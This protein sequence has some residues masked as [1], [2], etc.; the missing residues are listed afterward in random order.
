MEVWMKRGLKGLEVCDEAGAETLRRIKQQDV[1]KVAITKPRNVRFHRKFFALLNLVWSASGEW[2]SIE[3]LLVELKVRLG[4]VKEVVIRGTGE[5][6]KVPGSIA[7]ASMD[8][9][10][11]AVFFEQSMRELCEMAGGI[12]Y[13]A[14]R[15]E[16]LAQV[17][18]A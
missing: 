15:N 12:Q 4:L 14:L 3:D 13:E 17:S 8:D 9:L 2:Q 7:F 1:V 5:V 11:F 18:A 10:Q 6:V 16:V